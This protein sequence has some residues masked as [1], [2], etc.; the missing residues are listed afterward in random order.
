MEV[1]KE[2]QR[3]RISRGGFQNL[4]A[5]KFLRKQF[6]QPKLCWNAQSIFSNDISKDVSITPYILSNRFQPGIYI[7]NFTTWLWTITAES[8][9][10]HSS[11]RSN[12]MILK[13]SINHHSE[14][15][16]GLGFSILTTLSGFNK[17]KG[18]NANFSCRIS[19]SGVSSEGQRKMNTY[20]S[21]SIDCSLPQ[22][23]VQIISLDQSNSVLTSNSTLHLHCSLYH[24]MD[25]FFCGLSLLVIIE[26]N[27]CK[28]QYNLR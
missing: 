9:Y 26:K 22:L 12:G 18:S 23:M 5:L 8:I 28:S 10:T 27:G 11:N 3:L 21:H 17:H 25:D 14:I 6:G 20:P 24:T 19:V 15:S 2:S 1:G 7:H 13:D 16:P 4:F